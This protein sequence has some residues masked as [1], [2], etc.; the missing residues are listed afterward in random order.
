MA[1]ARVSPK[2]A[3]LCGER[4]PKPFRKVEREPFR[5]AEHMRK[6]FVT[7]GLI[8]APRVA[9][10][11][12]VCF[13]N[14]DAPMAHATN[15]GILFMLAIVGVVLTGFASF[16]VYLIRRANRAAVEAAAADAARLTP[17][18]GTAQC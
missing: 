15:T 2:L 12:P 14:S 18:E 5:R 6:A 8:L 13:G 3:R 7:L 11:C 1:S 9:L 10:A 16:F 4:R 17:S